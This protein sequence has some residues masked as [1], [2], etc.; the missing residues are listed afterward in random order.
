M[1]NSVLGTG[2]ARSQLVKD[3]PRA[4]PPA[5]VEIEG[6]P[7]AKPRRAVLRPSRLRP[8]GPLSPLVAPP[9]MPLDET[10]HERRKRTAGPATFGAGTVTIRRNGQSGAQAAETEPVELKQVASRVG[11]AAPTSQRAELLSRAP[12]KQPS[13][14]RATS[15]RSAHAVLSAR[16]LPSIGGAVSASG[17]GIPAIRPRVARSAAGLEAVTQV[18]GIPRLRR[19]LWLRERPFHSGWRC[20]TIGLLSVLALGLLVAYLTIQAPGSGCGRGC[21][22]DATLT[23]FYGA[24]TA[25]TILITIYFLA[26]YAIGLMRSR[27]PVRRVAS[28]TDAP[29]YVLVTPAHNEALVI[30]ETVRCMLR[31]RGR[32]LVMVVNDGSSDGTGEIAREAGEGDERLI[33]LDRSAEEAGQGKGEVLNAAYREIRGMVDG[34]DPRLGGAGEEELILCIVDADGWLRGDALQAVA[35]YFDD[36]DVA[37]V[38]IP[39]RMYNARRSFLACMQDIEFIGFSVLIQGGRDRLGSALLGGNGQFVRLSALRTLGHAPWTRA[40]TEDLDIGLRLARA[41][42]INRVCVETCV[43]Q[44]AVTRPRALL[45]QRTRWVQ[46]HYSCW[47]HL[48]AL[49][50]TPGIRLL[51][52]LDLSLHLVLAGTILIVTAQALMGLGGFIGLLPLGR[53][54]FASLLGSDIAYRAC[55]LVA[56]CGPLGMLGVA[57]QRAAVDYQASLRRRLPWWSLPGVFLLF[58]VY[59]YFWGLPSTFRAFARLMLRR[60]SWAKTA[61]EPLSNDRGGYASG[62]VTA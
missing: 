35:P 50:R 28:E 36:P 3:D 25:T 55:V 38:Q 17:F 4:M 47:S 33:V 26:L 13:G 11:L 46:G 44:Q 24:I 53:I 32:F 57:Y 62:A 51:T 41:G 10:V 18:A 40:L 9:P 30:A 15:V 23:L 45:R 49:W 12:F 31:L 52:R 8:S 37:A 19:R 43:A 1:S 6:P 21:A 5:T 39:V 56:A 29:L 58:T 16:A 27:R 42:W 59:V 54:P 14:S 7:V 2:A 60:G 34:G 22:P 48:P 61:R 20:V